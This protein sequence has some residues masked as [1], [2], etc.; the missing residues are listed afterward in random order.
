HRSARAKVEVVSN[1][2]SWVGIMPDTTGV[3]TDLEV[4]VEKGDTVLLLTDGATEAM[5]AAGQMLGEDALAA[6][7][8][9]VAALPL[10]QAVKS[11]LD[12]AL[13]YQARQDDDITLLMLR[14]VEYRLQAAQHLDLR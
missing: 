8:E 9:R 4:A 13:R 1:D 10:E 2:G 6:L 14:R 12:E 11:I 5:N 7:F 3:V